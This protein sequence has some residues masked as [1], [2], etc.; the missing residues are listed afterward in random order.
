MLIVK[1]D[2]QFGLKKLKVERVGGAWRIWLHL[3]VDE[4]NG[5]YLELRPN[6]EVIRGIVRSDG[7]EDIYQYEEGTQE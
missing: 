1:F 3:S 2:L 7:T 5:T 6:G 4:M